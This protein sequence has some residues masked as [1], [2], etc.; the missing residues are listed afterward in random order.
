MNEPSA[1]MLDV[2][3]QV[4][5]WI[6]IAGAAAYAY[7]RYGAGSFLFMYLVGTWFY[8]LLLP[9]AVGSVDVRHGTTAF[10][11]STYYFSVIV[12]TL[13]FAAAI[14]VVAPA[15]F[16]P[17]LMSVAARGRPIPPGWKWNVSYSA[18]LVISLGLCLYSLATRNVFG[19]DGDFLFTILG[20]D[21]LLVCYF[22]GRKRRG[23]VANWFFFFALALLFLYAGF[24]YRI[25]ILL[26]AEIMVYIS[27]RGSLFVKAALIALSALLILLLA[28]FGQVRNYGT[29]DSIEQITSGNF[30]LSRVLAMSGE[31]TVYFATVNIIE[32][33]EEVETIGLRPILLLPAHFIPSAIWPNKPRAGYLG[34]Y[35]ELTEGMGNSG[36]AMHD[37]AQATLMFGHLGLP[38]S[39]FLL[40]MFNGLMLR[41]GLSWSPN[42][43][44]TC[45]LLFLFA[46]IV[47]SRGY[48][49]QQVT[50]MLFFILPL[51]L[52]DLARRFS[53][54]DRR[55]GARSKF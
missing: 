29:F 13:F 33:L 25:A 49:A 39:A 5:A 48:L 51:L 11:T 16:R 37:I 43:Y 32:K 10:A 2:T 47:P 40:G 53:F 34:T 20:F 41:I 38:F 27:T 24:R 42:R 54:Q 12:Y 9:F 45:A 17:G 19:R 21:F 1:L 31:Q 23:P 44:Y 36:A 7:L 18:F 26:M 52:I 15:A 4:L 50:W 14:R 28:V 8:L 22:I 55:L 30:Q 6:L 3:V 46:V 35:L